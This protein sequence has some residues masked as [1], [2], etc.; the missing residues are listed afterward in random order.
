MAIYTY[1]VMV[2]QFA[3]AVDE[4]LKQFGSFLM[5]AAP[6]LVL[7]L[8]AAGLAALV[9][10]LRDREGL[11]RLWSG[12]QPCLAAL[13]IGILASLLLVLE[14]F[15]LTVSKQLVLSRR[16]VEAGSPYTA[17]AEAPIGTLYQY[18]PVAAYLRERSFTRTHILPVE[19]APQA[20]P[21]Q[22]QQILLS[23]QQYE[24]RTPQAPR[25]QTKVERVGEQ[26]VVTRTVTMFEEVP[27]TFDRAEVRA[28]FQ[29]RQSR[30]GRPF[31]QLDFEGRYTFRNP[32]NQAV[33]SRFVLP[34]PEPPGTL[35]GFQLQVDGSTIT[36]PNEYGQYAWEGM[37][38]PGGTL[39]AVVRFRATQGEGWQ[40]DIGSGRRRTGE[41]RLTVQADS[42][43]RLLRHSLFPTERSGNQMV[44]RLQNVI[45]SQRVE[46]AFPAD[47][48]AHETLVKV[49]T[50]Y[51][52]ALVAF[53]G[54]VLLLALL[55]ALRVAPLR[56]LLAI[57]GVGFGF[58]MVPVLLNYLLLG[59]AAL[60]GSLVAAGLGLLAFQARHAILTLLTVTTPLVFLVADHSGLL[61]LLIGLIGIAI[62][63]L[64]LMRYREH[65]L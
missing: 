36:E 62:L 45:T 34:L 44:W 38:A 59:W 41:F 24:S 12:V 26:L 52:M 56:V 2:Q 42:P 55:G 4:A 64:T 6:W 50:F 30:R 16:E 17:E 25:V 3:Q 61:L 37:L 7:L 13:G 53:G 19:I 21:E 5:S 65:I 48:T 51:P 31:H 58:L 60:I 57:V 18:G 15:L 1:A 63:W 49:L 43:P 39:T 10:Y 54:W 33:P 11:E 8:I 27:I 40:Y 14:V 35:E 9:L 20:T 46:L 47:A 28:R 32:L 29:I 22:L 23:L